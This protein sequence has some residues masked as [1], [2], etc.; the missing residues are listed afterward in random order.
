MPLFDKFLPDDLLAAVRTIKSAAT[1]A[2]PSPGV[3][4]RYSFFYGLIFAVGA[5]SGIY[6]SALAS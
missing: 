3:W 2:A 5:F 4:I 6:S 1:E